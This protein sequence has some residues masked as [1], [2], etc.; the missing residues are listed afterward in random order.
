VN[1]VPSVEFPYPTLVIMMDSICIQTPDDQ[2]VTVNFDQSPNK[3]RPNCSAS[4][5]A[6]ATLCTE[7]PA[8]L[9]D[10]SDEAKYEKKEVY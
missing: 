2:W 3:H 5:D 10:Y 8:R 6:V 4:C 7:T 1:L 9:N